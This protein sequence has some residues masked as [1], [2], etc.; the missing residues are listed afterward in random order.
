MWTDP[1]EI[2]VT[3]KRKWAIEK[4][5]CFRQALLARQHCKR[6]PIVLLFR[7]DISDHVVDKAN[8]ITVLTA[9]QI[10]R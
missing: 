10:L 7:L 5:D 6:V 8:E 4:E 1:N 9:V 2:T 3:Q